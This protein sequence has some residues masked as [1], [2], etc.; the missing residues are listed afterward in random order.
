LTDIFLK[1][2]ILVV[3]QKSSSVEG[4][5]SQVPLNLRFGYLKL[6]DLVK[7]VIFQTNCDKI[8]LK[9]ISFDVISMT[10]LYL[11]TEK[12]HQTKVTRFFNF[13]TLPI[14]ISGYASVYRVQYWKLVSIFQHTCV[15]NRIRM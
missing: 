10:S 9:K 15:F 7:I 13:G 6:R 14:K 1:C 12:R 3:F 8:E 4:S 5:P 2:I 11:R